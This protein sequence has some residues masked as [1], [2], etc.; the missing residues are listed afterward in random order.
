MLESKGTFT[1]V[2]FDEF[3]T[4]HQAAFLCEKQV[5]IKLHL[6]IINNF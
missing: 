6:L 2:L 3:T 4:K 1:N 5:I